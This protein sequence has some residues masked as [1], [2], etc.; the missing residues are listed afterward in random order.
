VVRPSEYADF[1]AN[2]ALALAKRAK[3]PPREL[4]ALVLTALDLLIAVGLDSPR[5]RAVTENN[6]I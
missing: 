5:A 6:R 3:R 1:Q 2:A 4:A